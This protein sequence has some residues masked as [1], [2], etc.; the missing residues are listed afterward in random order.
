MVKT[1]NLNN[2][3]WLWW[4]G[5]IGFIFGFP[6]LWIIVGIIYLLYDRKKSKTTNYHFEKTSSKWI[7]VSGNL[8][9]IIILISLVILGMVL[10]RNV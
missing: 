6:Y 2:K 8:V 9:L 10:I 4:T 1:W 3:K 5:L 7:I